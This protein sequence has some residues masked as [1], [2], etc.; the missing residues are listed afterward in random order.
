[1]CAWVLI[2]GCVARHLH[3]TVRGWG[4]L[5]L[6]IFTLCIALCTTAHSGSHYSFCRSHY[7]MPKSL[8]RPPG[9]GG[10]CKPF[11][12]LG[13][14][15]KLAK[16]GSSMDVCR[17]TQHQP[18]GVD[19]TVVEVDTSLACWIL[20]VLSS[21]FTPEP[22]CRRG[23]WR[24]FRNV[25]GRSALGYIRERV[26]RSAWKTQACYLLH[27]STIPRLSKPLARCS[28]TWQER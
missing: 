6:C 1:M 4:P 15:S 22:T 10:A 20:D 17:A 25:A 26:A 9:R 5:R 7:M 23:V 14:M 28:A 3:V 21:V 13:G 24:P 18:F 27:F 8:C 12:K 19:P 2:H 11:A 16:L